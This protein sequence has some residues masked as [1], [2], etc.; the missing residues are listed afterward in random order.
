MFKLDDKKIESIKE[1]SK[2]A[3][4]NT[5]IAM[6]FVLKW[7]GIAFVFALKNLAILSKVL[8]YYTW[9]GLKFTNNAFDAVLGF[10]YSAVSKIKYVDKIPAWLRATARVCF[11]TMTKFVAVLTL[12]IYLSSI[13][14]P[15]YYAYFT[16]KYQLAMNQYIV[17]QGNRKDKELQ[18]KKEEMKTAYSEVLKNE[19]FARLSDIL[20]LKKEQCIN[21]EV[22][23]F[24]YWYSQ[25]SGEAPPDEIVEMARAQAD[26]SSCSVTNL[27]GDIYENLVKAPFEKELA[28]SFNE[29]EKSR[30]MD[31]DAQYA[32]VKDEVEKVEKEAE[33]SAKAI[34]VDELSKSVASGKIKAVFCSYGHGMGQNGWTDNGA[35]AADG[36]TERD[37]I[38]P[39]V[40]KACDIIEK[41]LSSRGVKIYR[42][43][44]KPMTL[45]DKIAQVNKISEENGY[46][47]TNS[48]MFELHWNKVTDSSKSGTMVFFSQ[49]KTAADG[50]QGEALAS[51]TL[52]SLKKNMNF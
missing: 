4:Y 2:K 44:E 34:N 22:T 3:T 31:E 19:V 8:T 47:A 33:A 24:R 17:W 52:V 18:S 39:V 36:T 15:T 29:L 5:V 26:Y 35:R 28:V 1:F 30:K 43:G 25:E 45:V 27:K 38:V 42:I 21:R 51:K 37:L 16:N 48:I 9:E 11:T 14:A 40:G 50:L 13:F 10:F 20:D 41:E 49:L 12:A 46:D 6:A 7:A 32:Q 23:D